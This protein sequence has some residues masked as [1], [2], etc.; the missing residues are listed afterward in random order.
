MRN[1]KKRQYENIKFLRG[2]EYKF[3]VHNKVVTCVITVR[4]ST[5]TD[6][7]PIDFAVIPW[8]YCT[9]CDTVSGKGIAKCAD[10]DEFDESFG[11]RIAAKKARADLYH[12]IYTLVRGR[13]E[14]YA[15]FADICRHN[16]LELDTL[17]NRNIMRCLEL[18]NNKYCNC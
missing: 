17:A 5:I 15:S 4:T 11:K 9:S 8:A 12:K 13:M 16:I 2:A 10:G 1:Y 3:Y 18:I 14:M 6:Q 7:G